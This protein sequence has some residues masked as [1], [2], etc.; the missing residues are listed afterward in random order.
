MF[1]EMQ[2]SVRE[3]VLL[4]VSMCCICSAHSGHS[5]NT[6]GSVITDGVQDI[7][8]MRNLEYGW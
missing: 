4:L 5:S 2:F 6:F 3:L 1:F 8:E 7:T